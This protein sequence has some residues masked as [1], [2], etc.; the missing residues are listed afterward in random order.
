MQRSQRCEKGEGMEWAIQFAF[1]LSETQNAS[2][3]E[4]SFCEVLRGFN[5]R[6]AEVKRKFF[7]KSGKTRARI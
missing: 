6:F 4:L 5:V 3:T 2:T 1:R 7:Q